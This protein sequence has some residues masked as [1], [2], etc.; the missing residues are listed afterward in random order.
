MLPAETLEVTE[1]VVTPSL[2]KPRYNTEA[3]PPVFLAN[4]KVHTTGYTHTY[5]G[6]DSSVG[7]VTRYRLGGPGIESRW[8]RDF[9]HP[10]RQA[11]GPTQPP[12]Q[13]VLGLFPRGKAAGAWS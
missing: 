4:C 9:P 5:V 7:I 12:K 13:W 2:A 11:V 6:W 3:I 1:R 10:S 8:R